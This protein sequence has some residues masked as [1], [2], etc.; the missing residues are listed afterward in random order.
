MS[1]PL[2]T[3]PGAKAAM[4]PNIF[5]QSASALN[6]ATSLANRVGN[7]AVPRIN[8]SNLGFNSPGIAWGGAGTQATARQM[9]NTDLSPYM[10]PYTQNVIN[11]TVGTMND[12]FS[13][14]MNNLDAQASAAGAF[15]GS[16]HGVA[17][18]EAQ[19]G[20]NNQMASTV[21]GLNQ[22]NF[23]NAQQMA[24]Q[25]I[26]NRMQA[27]Q[28][29]I[30]NTLQA[31]SQNAANR[32]ATNQTNAANTLQARMANQQAALTT[33]GNQLNAASQLGNLS[34][35][36][37]GM[38]QQVQQMQNQ[39]GT[40]QQQ[41]QQALIDAARGQYG[42]FTGAPS[43]G[44]AAIMSAISGSP[45]PQSSTQSS[46]PGLLGILS[47]GASMLGGLASAGLFCWV[48]RSVYGEADPRWLQFRKWMLLKA[49][50]GLFRDYVKHGPA[51]AEWLDNNPWA[52]L[53]LRPFMD[54]AR[55]EVA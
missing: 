28:F 3:L 31:R 46:S 52:K 35:L 32:L 24:G 51:L 10:N 41:L 4:Q 33:Q 40:Q 11:T 7:T 49:P 37:F 34:N 38:G 48:A 23:A 26:A 55:A 42:G 44:L 30:G 39:A 54:K 5:Q 12:Q 17:M 20:F 29:N 1:S 13:Q 2:I 43:Q 27:Q 9:A 15:G 47:G 18:G 8:A 45:A 21:A 19:T 6:N 16:R 36:G 53:A 22:S 50:D 25:D 14:Q